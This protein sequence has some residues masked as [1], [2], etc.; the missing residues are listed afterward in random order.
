MNDYYKTLGVD[1]NATPDIIKKAYR[2]LAGVHHPDKGGDTA[3]FQQIEEAYRTLSDPTKKQQ[4][5]NPNPFGNGPHQQGFTFNMH[6]GMFNFDDIFGQMFRNPP[7]NQQRF[8]QTYRTIVYVTLE[9][10]YEGGEQ[11][12]KLQ[13]PTES[14]VIKIKVPKGVQNGEQMRYDNVVPNANLIV[15]FKVQEHLK[16]ERK[17]SDLYCSQSIS[18]LDLIIGTSIKFTTISGKEFE[19]KIP[20][21]TQPNT[22]MRIPAEGMPIFGSNSYG[23]QIILIKPFIPDIIDEEITQSILRSKSQ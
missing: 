19:V 6:N 3:K 16:Y 8:H 15:E 18:V 22:Q 4:Y 13:T 12:L 23:D 7:N 20:P 21:K 9:Q 1:R 11:N 17:G 5:D 10:S 14:H 2:K